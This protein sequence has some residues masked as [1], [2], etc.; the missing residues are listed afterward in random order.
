MARVGATHL[1]SSLSQ[2][3]ALSRLVLKSIDLANG[4]VFAFLPPAA[5]D[6]AIR[7]TDTGGLLKAS[8][9]EDAAVLTVVDHLRKLKS[10]I[11]IAEHA[12]ARCSDPHI[13]AKP[14]KWFCYQDQ[15]YYWIADSSVNADGVH[16]VLRNGR[17]WLNTGFVCSVGSLSE[18]E[19]G[20]ANPTPKLL[21][22]LAQGVALILVSAYDGEGYIF[23][24][25]R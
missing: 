16:Q 13:T 18:A 24:Q 12:L 15:V 25:K 20:L 19:A 3:K 22:D 23:W 7:H 17:S 5:P 8:V 2:G 4:Q 6:E 21:A 14:A 10:A 11:L 1:E 9:S